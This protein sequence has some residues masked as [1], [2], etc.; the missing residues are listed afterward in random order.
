MP[1]YS[2][3]KRAFFVEHGDGAWTYDSG[4]GFVQESG[5]EQQTARKFMNLRA[6]RWTVW[7]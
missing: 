1:L 6:V 2:K 3:Q 4:P 5:D 7:N